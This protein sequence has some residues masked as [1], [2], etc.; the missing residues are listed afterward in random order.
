MRTK[1]AV[2]KW[3]EDKGFGF[4]EP[5]DGGPDL[6]VHY[7]CFV[8]QVR[9]PQVGDTVF[10]DRKTNTD[11]KSRAYRVL[12]IGERDPRRMDWLLDTMY[13]LCSFA[14]LA[15]MAILVYA[16]QLAPIYL[17]LYIGFSA[18]TFF[19]YWYDKRKA[20]KEEQRIPERTL[21]F[22][23]L[24]GGWPGALLAQ[25]IFHHKSRKR[26]FQLVFFM[27]IVLNIT[28]VS[29]YTVSGL[30]FL[31]GDRV[32]QLYRQLTKSSAS[33]S[34][35]PSNSQVKSA[36]YSWINKDGKRVYSNVGF[37]NDEPYRDGRIELH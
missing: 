16:K 12:F 37:P 10:F 3:N 18:L 21:H 35:I 4:I 14:F 20:R 24:L 5:S 17:I 9:Q 28:F 27:T 22:S 13:S 26:S 7:D 11:G 19:L 1:G 2:V 34:T 15:F 30:N 31:N 33:Y 25:R 6:F 32:I 8:H 23:S 36:V 29:V